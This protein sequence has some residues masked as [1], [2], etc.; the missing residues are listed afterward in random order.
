MTE[1]IGV[2]V[3]LF[4]PTDQEIRNISMYKD[5]VDK[6]LIIDNSPINHQVIISNLIGLSKDIQY[7]SYTE[8]IG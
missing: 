6:I 5:E 8:N 2:I 7:V 3:V 4:K 1:M